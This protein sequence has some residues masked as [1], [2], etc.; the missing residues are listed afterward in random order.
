V[1]Y[2]FI[3]ES[4]GPGFKIG[5]GSTDILC[6]AAVVFQSE[7]DM[8]VV[9]NIIESLKPLLGLRKPH[10][11]HFTKE[12]TRIREAFCHAVADAPFMIRAILVKKERIYPDT[13]LRK[14]SAHFYNF[15]TRM[16]LEHSFG[17]IDDASVYID[18]NMNRELRSYL[19]EQLNREQRIV[20]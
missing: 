10:E 15:C 8:L 7:S 18:G 12:P 4:G 20:R 5:Y 11:F 19:R 17:A 3:D 14:S 2:V 16:L 13:M 6:I 9:E 1:Q